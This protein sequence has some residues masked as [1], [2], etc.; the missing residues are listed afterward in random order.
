[1]L[2]AIE[3]GQHIL[4]VAAGTGL[5]FYEIVE[6]NPHGQ[7]LGVDLSTGMLGKARN[8]L[9]TLEP[10]NFLLAIGTA[11][12]LPVSSGSIDL[13]VNNYMFDLI[14]YEEMDRVLI[15]FRR[16]L[17]AGGKLILVNMTIGEGVGSK[18]YDL[19]YRL[20]PKTMGG[21]RGVRLTERL[22]QNGLAV[23]VREYHQQMF[24]P[25]EVILARYPA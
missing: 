3:D 15:E 20:S 6:R 4:E 18:L 23:Q 8:R 1:A 5:A 11:F 13:L 12:D 9:K 25:S 17:K 14:S 24:F 7:N 21:C 16:V 22:R 2:A 10:G 19:I